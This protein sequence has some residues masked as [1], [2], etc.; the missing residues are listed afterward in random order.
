MKQ[1]KNG[2]VVIEEG[3]TLNKY[4]PSHYK[5]IILSYWFRVKNTLSRKANQIGTID[6]LVR[7]F[8][9]KTS[10]VVEPKTM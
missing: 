6:L 9:S 1:L 10:T 5:N 7:D 4:L 8:K 2:K 3:K